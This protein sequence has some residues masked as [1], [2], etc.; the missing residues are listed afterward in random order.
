[1]LC[2]IGSFTFIH[3]LFLHQNINEELDVA[4]ESFL[5]GEACKID[6]AKRE[7]RLPHNN[8]GCAYNVWAGFSN[9]HFVLL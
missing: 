5:E 6:M 3:Y 2:F 1:M 4:V 8:S 7:V 9:D